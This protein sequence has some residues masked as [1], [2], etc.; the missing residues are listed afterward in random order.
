MAKHSKRV[1]RTEPRNKNDGRDLQR[2][3]HAIESALK[4]SSNIKIESPRRLID[5]DTGRL[6]EH[7]VVLTFMQGHHEL[8]MSLECRDRSRPVGVPDVEAFHSKCQRTLIDRGVIVS[9][10]GFRKT[11]ITKANSYSIGCLSLDEVDR[12]DWCQ[13][14]AV[15]VVNHDLLCT[16]IHIQ[17]PEQPPEGTVFTVE[18]GTPLHDQMF[19][20]W[21]LLCFNNYVDKIN[22]PDGQHTFLFVEDNP[23]IYTT[24][25]G[26]RVRAIKLLLSPT[27]GV[28]R[29]FIPLEF[30]SYFDT[31]RSRSVTDAAVARVEVGGTSASLVVSRDTTGAIKV[32][33]VPA[34]TDP[35]RPEQTPSDNTQ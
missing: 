10:T 3:I 1:A 33:V 8:L 35:P 26:S 15:T 24:I 16:N 30:R 31:A 5:K 2:L 9:S 22:I 25:H 20:D 29:K 17:F 21:A 32:S 4:A 23:A 7:D 27:Y 6:R 13:T 11:A 28:S 14:P 19:R 18:N 12:F 34:P